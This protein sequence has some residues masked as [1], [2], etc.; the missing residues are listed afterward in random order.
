MSSGLAVRHGIVDG[1]ESARTIEEG[2]GAAG[3]VVS[4]DDLAQIVDADCRGAV[5]GQGIVE[6]GVGTA[7]VRIVE[8]AVEAARVLINADDLPR[9]V[10]AAGNGAL[11]R[12]GI[13]EGGVSTANVR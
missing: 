13:V 9:G 5:G 12:K 10:D 8:E 4:P 11:S 3:V 1:G 6:G 7:V 2:V